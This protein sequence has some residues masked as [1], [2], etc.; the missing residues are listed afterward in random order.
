MSGFQNTVFQRKE[1]LG[2]L[3]SRLNWD[4]DTLEAWLVECKQKEE[5]FILINKFS[6]Q[7]E[8]VIK[9]YI[10]NLSHDS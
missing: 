5:D 1:K 9:V 4:T 8:D 2:R 6:A 10:C 3:K 7:D